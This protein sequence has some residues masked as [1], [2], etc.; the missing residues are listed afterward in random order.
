MKWI[1]IS[2]SWRKTNREL[3][4]D[5]I[6][7]AG[8]IINRG[9]GII[10]G[11]ALN[12]DYFATCEAMKLDP[13]AKKI[14]IFLPAPLKIYAEH[15]R[16]RAN[17]GVITKNQAERLIKQLLRLQKIN[18]A[19]LIEN[20]LQEV[21]DSAVAVDRE[22]PPTKAVL[23]AAMEQLVSIKDKNYGQSGLYNAL[24][25]SSLNVDSVAID[26]NGKATIKLSGTLQLVGTCED[27][28]IEAQLR[29]TAMQFS[30]V[31][32]ADI[33][34]NNKNLTEIMSLEDA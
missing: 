28:R 18:P 6:K 24:Y 9:D 21:N 22:I 16:N 5:V 15:Y 2:G 17:E 3:E 11:G 14:K 31:K 27:P 32:S 12:V 20:N 7:T 34:I 23:K 26:D 33:F 1:G 13:K 30:T 4:K 29:E 8:E 25:Q 19:A 10:S